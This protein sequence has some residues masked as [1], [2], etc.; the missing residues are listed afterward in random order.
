MEKLQRCAAA[1]ILCIGT[2]S[3]SM[4]PTRMDIYDASDN[5]LLFVTFEISADGVCTGRNV[6]TS[7]STFLYHTAVQNGATGPVKEISSDFMENRL[8]TSTIT[9]S[10]G[11][12]DFSTVDQF[13]LTQFGSALSY[14]QTEQNTYEIKQ[15]STLICKEKYEY[16]SLG[17]L[18]RIII[19]D[20]NGEKAWYANVGYKEV[21]VLKQ[22][23]AGMFNSLKVSANRGSLVLRCKLNS[24]HFLSAEL[25]TPSGRRVRYLVNSKVTKGDHSFTLSRKELPANGAYIVRVSTDNVPMHVQKVFLQK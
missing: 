8:Y 14:A 22:G 3:A 7:D 17:M 5:L 21:G 24:G 2:V 20:K 12:T 18:S 23:S 11:K 9:T 19:F 6:Y 15:G 10:G 1:I 25:L 4:P 13:G 16:D